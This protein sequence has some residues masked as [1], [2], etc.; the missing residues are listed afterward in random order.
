MRITIDISPEYAQ[1]LMDHVIE[2]SEFCDDPNERT[3]LEAI[4]EA[5]RAALFLPRRSLLKNVDRLPIGPAGP[6]DK[7]F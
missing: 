3:E 5:F 6:N 1:V 4:E 2:D 7:P